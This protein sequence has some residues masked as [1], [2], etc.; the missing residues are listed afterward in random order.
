M[1]TTTDFNPF[2]TAIDAF[3]AGIETTVNFQKQAVESF[4]DLANAAPIDTLKERAESMTSESIRL[5]KTNAERSQKTMEEIFKTGMN[6]FEKSCKSFNDGNVKPEQ[7]FN[8]ARGVWENTLNAMKTSTDLV[9]K[10]N[11]EIVEGWSDFVTKS[12]AVTNGKK[13]APVG[14]KVNA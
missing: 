5:M 6:A 11:T 9:T 1:A 3:Q 7:F 10:A 8:E 14:A 2:K 13:V 4:G 12:F